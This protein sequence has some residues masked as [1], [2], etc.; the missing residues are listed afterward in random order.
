[1]R[2]LHTVFKPICPLIVSGS[3]S[4]RLRLVSI[5]PFLWI[6]QL[7]NLCS[8]FKSKSPAAHF[9]AVKAK[10]HQSEPKRLKFEISKVATGRVE[11]R[12]AW[13]RVKS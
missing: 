3:N 1:M 2:E 9:G 11:E 6:S 10:V 5:A 13:C 4:N 7:K 12:L 8:Q